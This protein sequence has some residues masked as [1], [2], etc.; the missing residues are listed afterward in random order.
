MTECPSP[1]LEGVKASASLTEL[2]TSH[3]FSTMTWGPWK[4]AGGGNSCDRRIQW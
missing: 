4:L 1:V 3:S 2:K